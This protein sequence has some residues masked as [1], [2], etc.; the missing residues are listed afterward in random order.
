M[1]PARPD[2]HLASLEEQMLNLQSTHPNEN[3]VVEE[4]RLQ[5]QYNTSLQQ[6]NSYWLQ[7]SRLQW[8][9]DGD[10]NTSFF[11]ATISSRRRR[12]TVHMLQLQDGSWTIDQKEIRRAFTRHFRD[13]YCE[14][15]ETPTEWPE[16]VM[17]AILQTLPNPKTRCSLCIL[18]NNHR[19]RKLQRLFFS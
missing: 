19:H 2:K 3:Q 1:P 4:R 8:K 12:N 10:L 18:K 6:I 9:I 5:E 15:D 14:P 13:I 7:R 16:H 17:Q 11:H